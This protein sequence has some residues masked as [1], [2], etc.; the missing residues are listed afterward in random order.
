MFETGII[1]IATIVIACVDFL[2]YLKIKENLKKSSIALSND[3]ENLLKEFEKEKEE[4]EK[5]KQT[6]EELE[7][8]YVKL[9]NME[10]QKRSASAK[11]KI[12]EM[13]ILLKEKIATKEDIKKAEEFIKN[14][15][16]SFSVV[17]ALLILGKIDLKTAEYVRSKVTGYK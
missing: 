14:N 17:D 4:L 7:K 12:T 8:E 6:H 3:Y 16:S 1:L 15:G 9:K 13:D 10:E 5:L 11:K 2:I